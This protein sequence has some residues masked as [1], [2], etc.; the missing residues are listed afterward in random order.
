[1]KL[2]CN[3]CDC[4]E[5]PDNLIE[6]DSAQYDRGKYGIYQGYRCKECSEVWYYYSDEME[7]QINAYKEN[8]K[9]FNR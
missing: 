8:H 5:Q 3:C 4:C 9:I 7:R 1:M 6:I 2:T